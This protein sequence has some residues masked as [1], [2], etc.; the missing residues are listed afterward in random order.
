MTLPR[1]DHFRLVLSERRRRFH[2]PTSF[3]QIRAD[4]AARRVGA[5]YQAVSSFSDNAAKTPNAVS[6]WLAIF[7]LCDRI[8]EIADDSKER[9]ST[10]ER[11]MGKLM[12]KVEELQ[13]E[14]CADASA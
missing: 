13:S 6:R 10:R 14:A 5:T 11:R 2:P 4:Y 7:D 12:R 3:G 9:L 1:R 8:I